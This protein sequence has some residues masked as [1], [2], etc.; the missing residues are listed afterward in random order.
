MDK[1]P[2]LVNKFPFMDALLSDAE[3]EGDELA[4]GKNIQY[5]GPYEFN[6][7]ASLY[8]SEEKVKAIGK[9]FKTKQHSQWTIQKKYPDTPQLAICPQACTDTATCTHQISYHHVCLH[10]NAVLLKGLAAVY[11]NSE[12]KN[13]RRYAEKELMKMGIESI[14]HTKP[15]DL[16]YPDV[17]EALSAVEHESNSHNPKLV[18]GAEILEKVI[19]GWPMNKI[20]VKFKTSHKTLSKYIDQ[21]RNENAIMEYPTL[22][23]SP[24]PMPT[25]M[26]EFLKKKYST[27]KIIA[28]SWKEFADN[29]RGRFR[30]TELLSTKSISN[31]A[32]KNYKIRSMRSKRNCYEWRNYR[33]HAATLGG[34]L[35]NMLESTNNDIYFLDQSV[36]QNTYERRALGRKE[37]T[38]FFPGEK[39]VEKVY[40][41]A[42]YHLEKGPVYIILTR[43]HITMDENLKFINSFID[44]KR[45][46]TS[47]N[48]YLFMDNAR[49]QNSTD[50]IEA[51]KVMGIY[52]IFGVRGVPDLNPIENWFALVKQRFKKDEKRPFMERVALSICEENF[53]VDTI[54]R[55]FYQ[56]VIRIIDTYKNATIHAGNSNYIATSFKMKTRRRGMINNLT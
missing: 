50:S 52:P 49:Y 47:N 22:E 1:V 26:E 13:P 9:A 56:N 23:R 2:T 7:F 17:L 32:R 20:C 15:G 19:N 6:E 46:Q 41:S 38:P 31:Y 28:K 53:M 43:Q 14:T 54:K 8:G 16:I 34:Y 40:L 48:T 25:L 45:E 18:R 55:K 42:I 27:S 44:K 3:T 12:F 36:F 37:M 10:T 4:V 11:E 24:M 33:L 5:I 51:M 39:K 30:G 21:C 35:M 29:I